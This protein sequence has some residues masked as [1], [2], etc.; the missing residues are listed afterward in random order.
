MP[1]AGFEP[2]I[3]VSERLQVNALDRAAIGIGLLASCKINH[4]NIMFLTLTLLKWRIWRVPNNASRWQMGFN[5]VFN[6]HHHHCL[7]SLLWAL[8]FL[9]SFAHSSLSREAFFQFLTPNILIS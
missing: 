2:T 7:D 9:R 4:Y 3:S 6:H 5:L 8:V 1:P